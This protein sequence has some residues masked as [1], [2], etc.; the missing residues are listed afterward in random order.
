MAVELEQVMVHEGN[1]LDHIGSAFDE[2]RVGPELG[3]SLPE[4]LVRIQNDVEDTSVF[5][6]SL[7][8]VSFGECR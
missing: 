6:G 8:Y 5:L 2:L 7:R 3:Y 4:L 1:A